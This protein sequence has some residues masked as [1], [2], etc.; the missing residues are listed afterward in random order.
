MIPAPEVKKT[1]NEIK[2][3]MAQ[4]IANLTSDVM[5]LYLEERNELNK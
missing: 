4:G 1:L 5:I 2:N 3:N